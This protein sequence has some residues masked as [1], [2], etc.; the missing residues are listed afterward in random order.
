M[1]KLPTKNHPFYGGIDPGFTG[2]IALMNQAG[3]D[4]RV[5]DMPIS[6]T[7]REREIDLPGLR[8]VFKHL[9]RMPDCA[10]GLEW[11]TTR[12]GEGAERSERFGRGKGYLEAFAFLM[13]LD[14][15]KLAPNL[16]KRRLGVPGKSDK[17]ANKIG[18]R[19]FEDY[20]PEHATLI[21]GPRGGIKSGCLDALLIAHFL[22]TSSYQG[23]KAVVEKF[24]KGSP[25][26][27]ALC[28][29]AGRRGSKKLKGII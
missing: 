13:G 2:A 6:G 16:W 25:E 7:G 4:V 27:M 22:R 11:P 18:A 23:M 19:L 3:T 17:E 8:Q 20:Y 12:P 10:V 9:R 29:R 5:W 15:Y 26:A 1:A 28:M 24:G 21:R 14:C